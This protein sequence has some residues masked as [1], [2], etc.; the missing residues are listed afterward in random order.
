MLRIA[1][2]SQTCKPASDPPD[3][4]RLVIRDSRAALHPSRIDRS[5][6]AGAEARR[7]SRRDQLRQSES[8]LRLVRD[9]CTRS[10]P[11]PR[12]HALVCWRCPVS[13]ARWIIPARCR[14]PGLRRSQSGPGARR[15]PLRR[16][17][18]RSS[19]LA[20][21]SIIELA[22]ERERTVKRQRTG[23]AARDGGRGRGTEK[24]R[25]RGTD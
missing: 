18:C 2:L 8:A 20:M 22:G 17:T 3:R 4:A 6:H 24:G 7:G 25:D 11:S 15:G 16:P 23:E 9:C 10:R 14:V 1:A 12:L 13:R 19:Y 21:L 5:L